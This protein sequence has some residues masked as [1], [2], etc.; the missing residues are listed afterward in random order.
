MKQKAF[1]I[2]CKGLSIKQITQMLL[3]GE[4]PTLNIVHAIQ[5]VPHVLRTLQR[6]FYIL[7]LKW[8]I[9]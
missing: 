4:S 8:R 6:F 3:E 1:F 7:F 5:Y 9:K 2:I